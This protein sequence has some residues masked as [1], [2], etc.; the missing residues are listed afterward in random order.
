MTSSNYLAEGLAMAAEAIAEGIE[1]KGQHQKVRCPEPYEK[2]FRLD[3]DQPSK[4]P[5]H[6]MKSGF[7]RSEILFLH[8]NYMMAGSMLLASTAFLISQLASAT[9]AT[10]I[11]SQLSPKDSVKAPLVAR[12]KGTYS[13]TDTNVNASLAGTYNCFKGGTW[14]LQTQ[15]NTPID[16]ICGAPVYD[17]IEVTPFSLIPNADGAYSAQQSDYQLD[18]VCFDVSHDCDNTP[19][20]QHAYLHLNADIQDAAHANMEDCQYALGRVRDLCHDNKGYTRGGWFTFI[21]GTSY[22]FDPS[23]NGWDQ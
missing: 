23:R 1:T 8:T 7:G 3:S 10:P 6:I 20:N 13:G 21:D 11:D 4:H 18:V 14:V 19:P 12:Q 16:Q 15:T 9:F 22:G 17:D 5:R 2:K